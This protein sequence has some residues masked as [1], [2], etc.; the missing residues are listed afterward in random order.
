MTTIN[1]RG[2]RCEYCGRTFPE[3]SVD[4]PFHWYCEHLQELT[5]EQIKAARVEYKSRLLDAVD[6]DVAVTIP[7][8]TWADLVEYEFDDD[9]DPETVAPGDV[10]PDTLSDAVE[11]EYHYHVE[12]RDRAD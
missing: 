2:R 6:A 10:S 3:G 8:D 5:D 12:G 1:T 4:L 9:V 11:T 7:E